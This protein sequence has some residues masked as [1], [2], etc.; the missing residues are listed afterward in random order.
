MLVPPTDLIGIS[1]SMGLLSRALER[2]PLNSAPP[3]QA[4]DGS[5]PGPSCRGKAAVLVVCCTVLAVVG[6]GATALG[7]EES[8][9]FLWVRSPAQGLYDAAA[10]ARPTP[11]AGPRS[12]MVRRQTRQ[13]SAEVRS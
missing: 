4:R 10:A 11:S 7:P 6:L 5:G 2:H 13:V 3:G 12:R 9:A 1:P 8:V